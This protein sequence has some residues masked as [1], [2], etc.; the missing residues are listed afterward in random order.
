FRRLRDLLGAD[1]LTDIDFYLVDDDTY[2]NSLQNDLRRPDRRV[3]EG[4]RFGY[5]YAMRRLHAGLF[6]DTEYRAG[7]F[8]LDVSLSLGEETLRRRGYCEKELFPGRGSAGDSPSA[9]FTTFRAAAAARYAFSPRHSISVSV[10]AAGEAPD[11]EDLFWNPQYNNLMVDRP[12][13]RK[14][15]GWETTYRFTSPAVR[16]EA[17][18]F[19]SMTCDDMATVRCYDD[20]DALFC[21]VSASGIDL[22]SY[23]V[24]TA[25]AVRL[26]RRWRVSAA[27]SAARY[28]YASNPVVSII[29]DASNAVVA[30]ASS[31]YMGGCSQGGAPQLAATVD[32][33]YF[34]RSGWSVGSA[35]SLVAERYVVPSLLRRPERMSRQAASSPE[36]FDAIVRQERL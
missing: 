30:D 21:D 19:A 15:F 22:L 11:A 32:V 36:E 26:S 3:G 14:R 8:G 10:S 24:E 25:V 18:L 12:V 5:D 7:R 20:L 33:D 34:S 31:S 4:D 13:L 6:A 2:S 29:A 28:R 1:F 17:S 23:G 35:V 16:F 9:A 27:I